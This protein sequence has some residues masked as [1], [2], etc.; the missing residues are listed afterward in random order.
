MTN[1][2][3][4]P[5]SPS[6]RFADATEGL[7][8]PRLQDIPELE[9]RARR[10]GVARPSL[11]ALDT[12]ELNDRELPLGPMT[13]RW[14][15][16]TQ[17]AP[18]DPA[19]VAK[20]RECKARVEALGLAGRRDED[21]R[22]RSVYTEDIIAAVEIEWRTGLRSISRIGRDFELNPDTIRQWAKARKWPSRPEAAREVRRAINDAVI[23]RATKSLRMDAASNRLQ[24]AASAGGDPL[25]GIVTSEQRADVLMQDYAV[26]VA[27][28]IEG[29]RGTAT[30]AL[31]V[32]QALLDEYQSSLAAVL[33][34]T[35]G[36]LKAGDQPDDAVLAFIAKQMPTYKALITALRDASQLQRQAFGIGE[37]QGDVAPAGNDA[38]ASGAFPATYEDA[39][40]AAEARGERL[41]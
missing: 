2:T 30:R 36:E 41:V 20:V 40:R 32:G 24:A 34:R 28:V 9:S 38:G 4:E 13:T 8:L 18:V 14:D 27:T 37:A 15:D 10:A 22:S 5:A 17:V 7:G 35:R 12:V 19:I 25:A 33:R 31:A 39:V 3:D 29:M 11:H 6:N 26:T 23:D 21:G 1:E 16:V